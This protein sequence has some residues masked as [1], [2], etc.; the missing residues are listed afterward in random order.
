MNFSEAEKAVHRYHNG[1]ALPMMG[2][3]S[4]VARLRRCLGSGRIW[5]PQPG[6]VGHHIEDAFHSPAYKSARKGRFIHCRALR[7]T[8]LPEDTNQIDPGRSQSHDLSAQVALPLEVSFGSKA[9]MLSASKVSPLIPQEQK[10]QRTLF[11]VC[12]GPIAD[13]SSITYTDRRNR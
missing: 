12:F 2:A 5:C 9:E 6:D 13:V 4:S 11:D 10:S 3:R 8:A 1:A 7:S